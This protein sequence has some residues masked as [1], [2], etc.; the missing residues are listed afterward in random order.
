MAKREQVFV[1]YPSRD[2]ALADGIVDAVRRAN[3]LTLPVIYEPWLFNDIAGAALISPIL[4]K[5]DDSP[6]VVADITYL[7][8]NVVYEI[9]FTIGRQKRVFLVKNKSI[10]GDKALINAVGIFDTLGYRDYETYEELKQWLCAHIEP[11]HI[12]F[13]TALDSKF[14]VYT[15]E[16]ATRDDGINTTISRVKKARY[17][18]RSFHGS[19]DL[20]MSAPETIRQVAAASGVIL[21]FQDPSLVGATEHNVRCIFVAGLAEGME[22]PTLLLAPSA[23]QAPLDI[24]DEI[25]PYKNTEDIARGISDFCPLIVEYSSRIEPSGIDAQTLLEALSIGDPRAENEMPTLGLYYLKTDQFERTVRGEANLVVGR[26]GSGKTALFIQARNKI[27]ADRR[28]I[29]VDLK[30]EGYQLIK[31][32]ED[33]LT[34]LSAG[35]RQHLI[36]AFWE[37]LILLEVAYKILEKDQHT[38]RHNHELHDLY[39]KLRN[40]YQLADFAS[41]GDFSE[42]LTKLSDSLIERYQQTFSQEQDAQRL[43]A[44]QVTEL[45][46]THDLRELRKIISSYLGHKSSVWVLFDNL[47]KGWSTHGVDVIDAI[48]LRCLVDAGRKIEREMRRDDHDF[49]CVV[50]V[51]N[52][53]YDH[54][55]RNSADF[56]KESR[57]ALDWSDPDMLWEMLRLRLVNGMQDKLDEYDFQTVWRELC[58][59]HYA[60]E[61]TSA[62]IIDRSLMRPRNVLKIFNHC[63]GFATNFGRQKISD[64]DIEKGI[65]AYSHDLLE[66]LDRELSDVYPAAKDLLYYF[67]D[68]P[69]V[70]TADRLKAILTESGLPEDD[71]EKVTDFLL[72]YGVLGTRLGE[73]DHFIYSVNYDLKVLKIRASRH[74]EAADYV[75]NPAFWPAL[76]IRP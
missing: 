68:A 42:R 28:N 4:E 63:R 34:Y 18:Y 10:D 3:A 31:L 40:T 37:Y 6:F 57:A 29:V 70:L 44:A 19:D 36:T 21:P 11:T 71:R 47:D 26:K 15:V 1:A 12:P 41:E 14:P 50:F 39:L 62:Y 53:V 43:T 13:S 45:L 46:Y 51:R 54:L 60:G 48:V 69:A 49:H 7:N 32:K 66:E 64:Q 65:V 35:A 23:F 27:R 56:G 61:E 72:Y 76:G 74:T 55:M 52:D 75:V 22:K 20:R 73:K 2:T 58:T 17:P 8:L 5:I 33:I 30:P 38:Y 24:K 16:P 59:S 25:T 9:G 67:L